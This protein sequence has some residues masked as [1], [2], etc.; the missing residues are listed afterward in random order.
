MPD[1]SP[2]HVLLASILHEANSLALAPAPLAH[3]QRQGIFRNA[4]VAER[5]GQT[6]TEMAG[7]LEA[8]DEAAWKVTTPIAVPLDARTDADRMVVIEALQARYFQVVPYVSTGPLLRPVAFRSN[9]R[10]L[11]ETPYPVMWNIEKTASQ[12]RATTFRP[13]LAAEQTCDV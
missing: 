6:R 8:A 10:G 5:F 4:E 11:L 3:F 13:C 12:G 9:L 1:A 7:F 2:P